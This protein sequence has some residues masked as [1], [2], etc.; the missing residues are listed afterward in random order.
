[1]ELRGSIEL[2]M[3]YG[4]GKDPKYII[5]EG[6]CSRSLLKNS[7]GPLL[8]PWFPPDPRRLW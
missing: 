1:M 7:W 3:R 5:K 2:E 8:P 4:T 6:G